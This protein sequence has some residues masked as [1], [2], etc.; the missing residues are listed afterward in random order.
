MCTVPV[1]RFHQ[2]TLLV[3]CRRHFCCISIKSQPQRWKHSSSL[4]LNYKN[5]SSTASPQPPEQES[6]S[7]TQSD[8]ILLYRWPTMKHF[9]FISRLKVYQVSAMLLMLPPM[10]YMYLSGDITGRSL[11]Y[12][13]VAAVGTTAVLLILSY[14]FRRVVGEMAY[15]SSTNHIRVSTLTF[16]GGRRDLYFKADDIIPFADAQLRQGRAIK[17]LEVKGHPEVFLYSLKYGRILDNELLH[18]YLQI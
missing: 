12:A 1:L 2:R 8:S 13:T 7:T 6:C 17:R 18:K 16:V 5:Y 14:Y 10:A 9:R 11:A 4:K 15:V 3:L